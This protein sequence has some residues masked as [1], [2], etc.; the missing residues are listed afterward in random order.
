MLRFESFHPVQT[1]EKIEVPP[2]ATE[3]TV[4]DHLKPG[5]TLQLDRAQNFCIFNGTQLLGING[6]GL[7][8]HACF[9][10]CSGT[11][12]TADHVGAERGTYF[13]HD[14]HL[15][16]RNNALATRREASGITK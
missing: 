2:G 7:K 16:F 9:F 12:Q 8:L 5:F 15:I 10:D 3:F 13:S 11:Q 1:F 6:T 4:G 14:N